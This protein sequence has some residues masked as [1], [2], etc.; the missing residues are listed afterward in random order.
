MSFLCSILNSLPFILSC[1]SSVGTQEAVISH[2]WDHVILTRWNAIVSHDAATY[3][4][5]EHVF[6]RWVKTQASD[7]GQQLSCG[8][9]IFDIRAGPVSKD[10]ELLMHHGAITINHPLR[11]AIVEDVVPWFQARSGEFA[12]L[13]VA[14]T[15]NKNDKVMAALRALFLELGIAFV[16]DCKRLA[17]MT[18]RTA[19]T[20]LSPKVPGLIAVA[21]ECIEQNYDP[22]VHCTDIPI[23]FVRAFYNCWGRNKDVAFH[24]LWTSMRNATS[25]RIPTLSFMQAHWQYN[26]GSI[27]EGELLNSSVL[28]DTY[29]SRINPLVTAAIEADMK[30]ALNGV[31][32]KQFK[33]LNGVEINAVCDSGPELFDVLQKNIPLDKRTKSE[34]GEEEEEERVV[35]DRMASKVLRSR[36]VAV[37][38][39]TE[40]DNMYGDQD[41]RAFFAAPEETLRARVPIARER[42]RMD[43]MSSTS[44]IFSPESDGGDPG[45]I[46]A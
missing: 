32:E 22:S 17:Q 24:K 34:E 37:P 33:Y 26:V 35:V 14:E 29:K 6:D 23:P 18:V 39:L 40:E 12:I 11:R 27:T 19:R 38:R 3:Y 31:K 7:W 30:L 36:R 25:E 1:Q 2:P 45:E 5:T 10:G 46:L 9:R 28:Q 43:A 4:A 13:Y 20:T 21:E 16:E 42:T 41:M 8:A 44:V 15:Q